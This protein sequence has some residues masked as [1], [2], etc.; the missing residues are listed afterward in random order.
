MDVVRVAALLTL[1]LT[2]VSVHGLT[3]AL[4]IL[5]QARR[6][7]AD[8]PELIAR[9]RCQ[10]GSIMGRAGDLKVAVAELE[11]VVDEPQW[12]TVQER[13]I[14]LNNRGMVFF[15]LG[16]PTEAIA[17]FEVAA[18]LA[19]ECDHE[20]VRFM[21]EHNRGFTLFLSGDLPGALAAMA[22]AEQSPAEVFRGPSLLDLG[23]VMA[24]VGLLDEA[25]ETLDAAHRACRP[26][27][28]DLLRAEIDAERGRT[29]LLA[30]ECDD[31]AA[32]ARAARRRFRR[33]RADAL[34]AKADL[35]VLEADLLRGRRLS[36]AV[37]RALA[38]EQ[39]AR[40]LGDRDLRARAINVVAEAASR[41]GD[42][43]TARLALRRY[44]RESFGLAV[45]LRH[46][47][48]VAV[49]DIARGRSPRPGLIAAAGVLAESQRVSASLE[50]RAARKVLGLRLAAL[51]VERAVEHG[52]MRVLESLE[53]WSSR[54]LP[55]IR[56]PED[57][58][59]ADLVRELRVLSQRLIEEPGSA[60]TSTRQDEVN[61]LRRELTALSLTQPHA[62]PPEAPLPGIPD[63]LRALADADRDLLWLF[64]HA[65]GLWGVGVFGGRRSV[66]RLADEEAC[67]EATR[68]V[69]A[70]LRAAAHPPPGPLGAA[71]ATSL[72]SVTSWLD[73]TLIRPWHR[74]SAGLVIVDCHAAESLP[75]AMIP[76]L[77]GVPVTLARSLTEWAGRVRVVD[78]PA[79]RVV[80]GP[81]LVHAG[82]EATAV[83]D[84]WAGGDVGLVP[85]ARV[86]DLVDALGAADLVH[87]AAHGRHRASNPL[88]SSLR[89]ADGE[90]YAHE[91]PTGRITA[92]HVVL[93]ACEA[94]TAQVR[95]GDEP[96]G[97]ADTL[98]AL[99][100][101]SVVAAVG[102]VP[103]D[104]TAEVMAAYHHLLAQGMA[105]D[106][107]LA[108]AGRGTA[109]VALG[110]SWRC[111]Q[112]P[113]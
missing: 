84:A 6:I 2:E 25:V 15:E 67:L 23:R 50:S 73:E 37:A 88:F 105:S 111:A 49:T 32:A 40:A 63:S 4:P 56:P 97:M 93:S 66:R 81:G 22:E 8:D 101:S 70:D 106:E 76:S 109:F 14:T 74:R 9:W 39:T 65:G 112:E 61:R 27:Q 54:D 95:P 46:A 92:G 13:A 113:G 44:P 18:A 47:Y 17:S 29:L 51:D 33:L 96:L 41:Q 58:R 28:D 57:S 16:R 55:V 107:A 11:V 62:S 10:R 103:D 31:A 102:P 85:D 83:A 42:T 59:Q 110:S 36:G 89:L 26:R 79:V 34:A 68:R 5:D 45:H 100:V 38:I 94:G 71:I 21:A 53:R 12:F 19:S 104:T 90:V 7:A 48:A 82:H 80:P 30:G 52:P 24:E 77:A 98:L 72:A 35:T 3:A 78:D 86:A 60:L 1:A 69:R 43:D 87:V 20:P 75:W 108:V 91:L 99:G 64:T